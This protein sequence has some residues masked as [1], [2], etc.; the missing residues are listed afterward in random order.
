M[1]IFRDLNETIEDKKTHI[2]TIF[3][4]ANLDT[5]LT[6]FRTLSVSGRTLIGRKNESFKIPS[7]DGALLVESSIEPRVITVK[8]QLEAKNNS[9]FRDKF[10]NLNLLLHTKEAK[11]LKFSDELNYT[12]Y[13]ILQN[14]DSI[15]ETTNSIV[16]SFSFLC[17]SPF[18]YTKMTYNASNGVYCGVAYIDTVPD[19]ITVTL[20][21]STDKLIVR[22]EVTN[23]KIVIN[24]DFNAD[25][26]VDIMLNDDYILKINN[27][28]DSSKIDFLETDFDFTVKRGEKISASNCKNL[29]V[30]VK[31]GTY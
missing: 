20:K 30:Y 24:N 17:L 7:K 15:E 3:N 27:K 11:E 16:S 8:Y 31:G 23:K 25:D 10:N 28:Y 12:F 21:N 14:V 18:K 22:N 29:S 6:G 13:A 26:V 2:Q 4:G 19:N 9:D 5:T 1:Y